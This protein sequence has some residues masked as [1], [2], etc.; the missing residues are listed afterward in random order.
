MSYHTAFE[1]H[2]VAN[3]VFYELHFTSQKRLYDF[4][5]DGIQYKCLPSRGSV[6]IV[7]NPAG[8]RITTPERTVIDS[9]AS[10]EKIG[11]LEEL[12]QCMLLI[13]CLSAEKLLDA[14]DVYR[15]GKLFQIT[16]YLLE[17]FQ[18]NFHLPDT[19]F[20]ICE[21]R[22]SNSKA[23]FSRDHKDCILHKRWKLYAPVGLSG[24]LNK[25]VPASLLSQ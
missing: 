8:V 2:G 15:S 25:G 14:L 9:I 22:S 23:Y 19:F 17:A 10:F 7:E 4:S 3:Q 12:L 24:L 21:K 20:S 18:D 16:G 1:Y 5:Y 11:G 6:G 13:P